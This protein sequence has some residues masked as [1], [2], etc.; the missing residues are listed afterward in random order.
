MI[1]EACP[2]QEQVREP[3]IWRL[4]EFSALIEAGCPVGRHELTNREWVLLGIVRAEQKKITCEELEA[5]RGE[6]K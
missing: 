1:C 6:N 2:L 4:L 5:K 3:V